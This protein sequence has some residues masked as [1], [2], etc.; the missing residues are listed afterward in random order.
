M[1][2]EHT[3]AI[4]RVLE[5]AYPQ[6][7]RGKSTEERRDALRLWHD[8]FADRDGMVV[9]AAVKAFI[10]TDAKGFP[11]SIG[12]INE[13]LVKL[14]GP[15]A[16]SE[17]EAWA[18]VSRAIRKSGYHAAEAFAALPPVIQQ[19]VSSPSALRTW[20][21]TP[22]EDLETVVA[23]NFMRSYRLRAA[24]AREL[25][26][27]PQDVRAV[28]AQGREAMHALPP[29]PDHDG[30]QRAAIAR[31][32]ADR[33]AQQREMLGSAFDDICAE[34]PRAAFCN[35]NEYGYAEGVRNATDGATGRANGIVNS[36]DTEDGL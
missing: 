33:E 10:A 30:L 22:A 2:R 34:T 19:V 20:A 16:L 31:L 28:L 3:E 27:L 36:T 6:F 26:A 21:M 18:L 11:P 8:M 32:A 29:P 14:T 23:S 24:E 17:Q 25:L 9:A 5:T 7:Y 15:E 13:K 12:Q 1:T 35:E 4:L